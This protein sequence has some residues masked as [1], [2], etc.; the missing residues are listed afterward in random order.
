MSS[1]KKV[2]HR[3]IDDSHDLIILFLIYK[4]LAYKGIYW[5]EEFQEST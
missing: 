3:N 4:K 1:N 2:Y 5:E